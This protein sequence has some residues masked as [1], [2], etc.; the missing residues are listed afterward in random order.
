MAGA[1]DVMD[2]LTR[3]AVENRDLAA[4]AGLFA[5]NVVGETPDLG[6]IEGRDRLVDYMRQFLTSFPDVRFEQLHKLESGNLAI[7][8]GRY[9]GTNTGPIG[10]PNGESIPATG[11]PMSLR[12]CEIATIE[13]GLITKY[14]FYFDQMELSQ[15]LGLVPNQSNQ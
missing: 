2:E 8:V 1:R 11:K 6:R 5:E 7:D 10:L 12:S 4:A 3:V 15:Q 14:E 9:I 13:G